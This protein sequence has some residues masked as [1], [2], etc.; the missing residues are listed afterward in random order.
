[1]QV[2][3]LLTSLFYYINVPVTDM[4]QEPKQD[5]EVVS[6]AYYSESIATLEEN[7]DWVKIETQVDKYQGWVK[8]NVVYQRTDEFLS[9]PNSVM[10]KV[11]RLA[12]H[13]YHVQDTIYGPIITLPYESKL[14]VLDPKQDSSGRWIKVALVDGKEA[15]V[16]RGDVTLNPQKINRQDMCE[17]SS[18]F[19]GLPYTWGGRSSFGYDCS[20]FAQMLYR[21]M[22]IYIPRDS[23]DQNRW[24]GFSVAS[25]DTLQ[26]GDLIFFGLAED[27]IRHVGMYLGDD[28]FIHATV[29]ENAPYIHIS[30][31][32]DL[33]WNGSG[34]YPYR[35]FRTIKEK[36]LSKRY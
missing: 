11:N 3:F 16:Q 34:K 9:D 30:K 18:K 1:M 13:I 12:A 8:K 22:N 26:P 6:Q 5:S 33:E 20:G 31:L 7:A 35:T 28:Q 27:K 21:Q 24:D 29:A 25:L 36:T 19:L 15:F 4:R 17:L 10:A 14:E 2:I 23:K 32:T